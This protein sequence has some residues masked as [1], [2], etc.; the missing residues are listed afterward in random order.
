M[1]LG[2]GDSAWGARLHPQKDD[3]FQYTLSDPMGSAGGAGAV[4][5]LM[6]R[7]NPPLV[8]K[9]YNDKVLQRIRT[10][11]N[12]AQRIIAL[13]VHR[14]DLA[15]A[16]PFATWPRRL[17]FSQKNP[18]DPQQALLGFTM[19]R[20]VGT[21]SLLDL[22]TQKNA[23]LKITPNATAFLCITLADQIARMHRHPWTFVFGDFSPN[24]VHVT[25][26]LAQVRFIDT[27]G[28]QFDYNNGKYA[29][30]LSGL[31]NGFKSPG[32]DAALQA[33]GRLT[34]THDDY[35]LAILIFM[36]LM[37]DKGIPTHPFQCGDTPEDVNIERRLF[38][39]ANP[40]QFPLP[41]PV[42]DGFNSLPQTL[43]DTF[44]RTFTGPVPVPA[45][46]WIP[47]LS[48]YRRCL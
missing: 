29:F 26:N 28:F 44:I 21:V 4:Y 22:I 27:D 39:L 30:A 25:A 15:K 37:A 42:I 40:A 7:S 19:E 5:Q 14:D 47:I 18:A 24:N 1:L 13:A 10:D 41:T 16:L 20:L 6:P 38:P 46:A 43:R 34:T 36:L 32:A 3:Y 48:E 31:T 2:P 45:P 23:R 17:I 8:A 33:K 11:R 9:L 12:Y 35:V